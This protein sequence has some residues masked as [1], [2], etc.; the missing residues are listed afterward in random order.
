MVDV[1]TNFHAHWDAGQLG[2]IGKWGMGKAQRGEHKKDNRTG[3]LA[4]LELAFHRFITADKDDVVGG[5]RCLTCLAGGAHIIP[6]VLFGGVE[7][8]MRE[9]CESRENSNLGSEFPTIHHSPADWVVEP[10]G[11][12]KGIRTRIGVKGEFSY[13]IIFSS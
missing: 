2:V 8:D 10:K 12:Y 3:C 4:T 11:K 1:M 9:S 13:G 6:S 5:V 7:K